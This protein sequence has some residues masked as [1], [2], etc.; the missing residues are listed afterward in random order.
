[1][2]IIKLGIISLIFFGLFLTGLSLFFPSHVRI[3]RATDIQAP[4]DSVIASL[5]DLRKWHSWYPGTDSSKGEVHFI[6]GTDST[7]IFE[8]NIAGRKKA[9][10]G[11]NIYPGNT[12]NTFT[13]QWYMD[14]H[15]RWYPWEK[16]SGLLLEKRYGPMMEQGL[17]QLKSRLENK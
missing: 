16:F 2:R 11:W 17:T 4:K 12:P 10:V 6:S 9:T 15:L 3:S 1:M 5:K 8:T 14:F 7:V 13:V